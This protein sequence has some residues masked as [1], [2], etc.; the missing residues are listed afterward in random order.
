M[1]G[2]VGGAGGARPDRGLTASLP[3]A[4]KLRGV[5]PVFRFAGYELDEA[6]RR[7]RQRERELLLQPRVFDLLVYLIRQREKVVS[8]DELIEAVWEGAFIA[9]GAVQRAVSLARSALRENAPDAIRTYPRQGYR[10]CAAVEEGESEIPGEEDAAV[11]RAR[12]A[13]AR[14][15]WDAVVAASQVAD[16]AGALTAA[17]LERWGQAAEYRGEPRPAVLPLQRAVAAHAAAGDALGAARAALRVVSLQ[18]ESREL[19]VAGGWLRRAR[20]FL[21]GLAP[22]REHGLERWLTARYALFGK[23]NEKAHANAEEALQIARRLDDP[24][25]E[26]L[27]LLYTGIAMTTLGEV[28]AGLARIDEAAAAVLSGDV[29]SWEGGVVFCGLIWS[30]LNRGDWRRAAEWSGQFTRWSSAHPVSGYPGLCQLHRAE[31]LSLQGELDEAEREAEQ[32][33]ELIA[34]GLPYA[35]GDAWR[36]LGEIRLARADL[37]G[38]EEAFRRAHGLGWDPNPGYA[39]LQVARGRADSAVRG[40]QRAVD[41]TSWTGRQRR[42]LLLA[43]LVWVAAAAGEIEIAGEAMEEL[44]RHPELWS[45]HG[46]AAVVARA[47]GELALARGRCGE[48]VAAF[49]DALR[50]WSE[51]PAPCQMAAVRLRLAAAL[52]AEGDGDAAELEISAA[53]GVFAAAG[54]PLLAEDCRKLRRS[55]VAGDGDGP[56]RT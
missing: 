54:V 49:R 19:A 14:E 33:R 17:D 4:D 18:L 34:R 9:D 32:A 27:G 30:C 2:S 6:R 16:A 37:D 10:F 45:T 31:V 8:K 42:G 35:E 23:D 26:A 39:L 24:D 7:L 50:A 21:E 13:F 55:L 12:A 46:A 40:L 56:R 11:L 52:A 43:H 51:V 15:D 38:A 28:E 5:S 53:E 25:L 36:V 20:R 44:D 22:C 3:V 29:G 1:G 41:D 47:R 48:A